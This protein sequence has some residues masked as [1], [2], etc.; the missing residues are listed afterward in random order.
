MT[1]RTKHQ[2][3]HVRIWSCEGADSSTHQPT[4]C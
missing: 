2:Q 1:S 3:H 4:L